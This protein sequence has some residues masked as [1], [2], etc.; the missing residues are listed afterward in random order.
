MTPWSVFYRADSCQN[1]TAD[2][3][4]SFWP[5]NIKWHQ[6]TEMPAF[7]WEPGGSKQCFGSGLLGSWRHSIGSAALRTTGLDTFAP[8]GSPCP[9]TKNWR[10]LTSCVLLHILQI[11]SSVRVYTVGRCQEAVRP[12]TWIFCG[13]SGCYLTTFMHK[14][15]TNQGFIGG[16]WEAVTESSMQTEGLEHCQETGDEPQWALLLGAHCPF[17]VLGGNCAGRGFSTSQTGG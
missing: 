17:S 8:L 3:S 1:W 10:A 2:L 5:W 6:L 14:Y 4:S 13:G 16:A 11:G 12:P 9:L 15:S 7:T